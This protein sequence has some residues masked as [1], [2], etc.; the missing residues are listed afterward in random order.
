MA[1]F[2]EIEK[3]THAPLEDVL[4]RLYPAA[5]FKWLYDVSL[6]QL[7]E[8]LPNTPGQ[9][10]SARPSAAD[11]APRKPDLIV[12]LIRI[13]RDK[14]LGRRFFQL[15]PGPSRDVIEA[16]TWER[17]VNLAALEKTLGL[18]IAMAN[19]DT[20][21]IY[22]EPFLLPPEHGFLALLKNAENQWDYSS[23][24]NE[25]KKED[26]VLVLPDQIRNIIKSIVPPP[27]GFELLPLD[28]VPDSAGCCYSCG[29]K[30]ITDL[31]LVAEYIAQGHLK[32]SKTEKVATSSLKTLRQMTGGPELFEDDNDIELSLLHTRLL[33]GGMAFAGEKGREKLLA[34][35]N[36]S[37]AVRDLFQK[38]SGSAPFLHEDLLPHFSSA[39]NRWC[40]YSA[41]SGRHL[42]EFFGSIPAAK[43]V[44]WENIRSYHTLREQVP[45]LFRA[46]TGILQASARRPNDTWSKTVEV[47]E[48]NR[49]PLVSEPLLKGYAFLLAAFGLA[50]IDFAAPTHPTYQRINKDYLTPYDGLRFV[51]LTPLGEF[52][53]GQREH[54]DV[55]AGAPTRSPILLG[56]VRLLAT[57]WNPD[58]LTELALAQFMEVLAP[59]RYRMTPKSLLGGCCCREDIEERI[60]L[61]R[62][63]VAA[64]PPAIWEEL[65]ERTLARV[66]PLNLEPDYV[67]LKVSADEEIRRLIASDPVLRG[68]VLKVEGLRIA[69][70]RDDL[71]K[72]AKRLEQFGYLSPLMGPGK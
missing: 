14:E 45:S 10:K 16:A 8:S 4:L 64:A 2:H 43:W 20:R 12:L 70:R 46:D 40:Q 24:R 61:F 57:C 28:E 39:R 5:V 50:E 42:A 60:R 65:F 52:V 68:I 32:Y 11:K 59:G 56:E 55:E 34:G 58:K 18:P 7:A 27:L 17:C 29:Q 36:I 35:T 62:R 41:D 21:R 25:P 9:P 22:F 48:Q 71:K 31:R 3:L 33:V 67:V 72:L 38:I 6:R 37:E 30:A 23:A 53:H 44:S 47:N 49:F 69:V 51:R 15:L 63:V 54:Y 13:L 26:Y 1:T 19:P 66:S